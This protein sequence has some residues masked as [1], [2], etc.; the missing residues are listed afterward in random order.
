MN[1]LIH[2]VQSPWY[3][4]H[5]LHS[6]FHVSVCHLLEVSALHYKLVILI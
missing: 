2:F 1:A 5:F 6:L 4:K 3:V